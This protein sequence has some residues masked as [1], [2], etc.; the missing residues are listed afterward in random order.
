MASPRRVGTETSKTRLQL[1]DAVELLLVDKGYAA[2]TYRAVAARAGVTSGLVQYYFP[3][4]DDLLLATIRRR[5]EQ[6]LAHL[7]GMLNDR[8]DQPL[9]VLWEF[10]ND[11]TS[12]ALTMELSAL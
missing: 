11:E 10:S 6:S 2:V 7:L 4:F 9:R 5:T 12:A 3:T 8:P 1:L